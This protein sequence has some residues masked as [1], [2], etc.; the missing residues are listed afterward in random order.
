MQNQENIYSTPAYTPDERQTNN[1]PRE[2]AQQ[3]YTD[4]SYTEGY[5]GLDPR[6]IWSTGEKMLPETRNKKGMGQLLLVI[7]LLCVAFIAGSYFGVL[8]NWLSWILISVLIIAALGALATNWR[9]VIIPMPTRTFQITEHAHLAIKNGS[10]KVIIRRGEVDQIHVS[11]TKRASGLG[12]NP[13]NMQ[14][15]YD[16]RSDAVSITTDVAWHIFQFGLRSIDFEITVPEKCSVQLDNGSG[17][18]AMQGIHGN[19]RVST[20]SGGIEINDL[21]G[22]IAMRTGSGGIKANN[23]QGQ[24][25]VQTGSG[26]IQGYSLRGQVELKTGSGGIRM[27]HS[28]LAGSSR[29]T[30]GSGGIDFEGDLD[31]HGDSYLRTGSGGIRLHLP[32]H[33]AFRLDAKTGSGGVHNAFG[34]NEVGSGPRAQLKLRTGSG[35]IHITES[36]A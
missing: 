36:W 22:Q 2:Q 14:I 23:I 24:V 11:A 16:Q 6:D 33:T 27:E 25:S 1:D 30:T 7:A 29:I 21:Q 17:R 4:R 10:G 3:E 19:V 5:T 8:L 35:G 18:I 32:T 9:V 34:N 13:E 12:I 20:G 26:G 31:P 15:H 28:L